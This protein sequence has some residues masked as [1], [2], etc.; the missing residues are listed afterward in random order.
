MSEFNAAARPAD[1]TYTSCV[2]GSRISRL[3][4]TGT[5]RPVAAARRHT[6]DILHRWG[7]ASD[8][9][10]DAL[11]VAAELVAHAEKRVADGG[12]AREF[13]LTFHAGN[14][15]IAVGDADPEAGENVGR[16]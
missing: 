10:D 14:V 3:D 16:A 7:L 4:L 12:G 5:V 9:I 1:R 15:S 8:R 2:T 13:R 11:L 6:R